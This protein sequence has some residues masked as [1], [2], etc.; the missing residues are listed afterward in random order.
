MGA[1]CVPSKTR[2]RPPFQRIANGHIWFSKERDWSQ[3]EG[4]TY[5]KK[6]NAILLYFEKPF[7]KQQ[8]FFT[9]LTL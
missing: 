2:A 7:N 8:L 1:M 5:S 9:S 3:K 6:E 4:K